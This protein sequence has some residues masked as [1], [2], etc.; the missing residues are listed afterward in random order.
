M[1][2]DYKVLPVKSTFSVTRFTVYDGNVTP[3]VVKSGITK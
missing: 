3:K 1:L 2:I